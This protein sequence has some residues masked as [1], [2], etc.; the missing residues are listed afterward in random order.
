MLLKGRE[1]D[2]QPV[3][4][5]S[6]GRMC[7]CSPTLLLAVPHYPEGRAVTI[8]MCVVATRIP[9][10][11]PRTHKHAYIHSPT[12][13]SQACFVSVLVIV[14]FCLQARGGGS[15]LRHTTRLTD[16]R[17]TPVSPSLLSVFPLLS[18]A[19]SLYL[20]FYISIAL[21]L[22]HCYFSTLV[23]SPLFSGSL[24]IIGQNQRN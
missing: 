22:N 21:I 1:F 16:C 24:E 23:F 11:P 10:P 17:P 3:F 13:G 15:I 4:K 8:S 14:C 18:A 19:L 9:P 5:L 7:G 20:Y 6:S 2:T 12:L